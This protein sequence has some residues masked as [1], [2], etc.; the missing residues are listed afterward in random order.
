MDSNQLSQV[1]SQ[2]LKNPR[3]KVK[4]RLFIEDLAGKVKSFG[5]LM[6]NQ[7]RSLLIVAREYGVNVII[8]DKVTVKSS[9][10]SIVINAGSCRNCSNGFI[11]TKDENQYDHCFKCSCKFGQAHPE[12]L[13]TYGPEYSMKYIRQ[14]NG[15][16][17][18]SIK[19]DNIDLSDVGDNIDQ[20][21]MAFVLEVAKIAGEGKFH[22]KQLDAMAESLDWIVKN[23]D[24]KTM[25]KWCMEMS[26]DF[27][28]PYPPT[29]GA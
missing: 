11:W 6:D 19:W 16:S 13:P 18:G 23:K 20:P 2:L 14:D 1:I 7:T 26:Q 10:Q 17:S 25:Q 12:K 4:T 27:D 22:P 3:L 8:P 28:L 21:E 24:K 15:I 5:S 9:T 29:P